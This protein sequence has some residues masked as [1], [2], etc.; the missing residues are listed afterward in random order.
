MIP[1][2]APLVLHTAP[3]VFPISFSVDDTSRYYQ[4][5]QVRRCNSSSSNS[6]SSNGDAQQRPRRS[7]GRQPHRQNDVATSRLRSAAW[8]SVVPCHQEQMHHDGNDDSND[9]ENDLDLLLDTLVDHMLCC[10]SSRS[11]EEDGE[12]DNNRRRR[13][14]HRQLPP[15]VRPS[16]SLDVVE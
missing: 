11:F 14:R 15:G 12:G 4:Q 1:Y 2:I 8:V 13:N 9:N 16:H 3:T 10:A 5:Q 7:T 6:D